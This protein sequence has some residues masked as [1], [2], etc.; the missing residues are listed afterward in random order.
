MKLRS[1][2]AE[3]KIAS[4][5]PLILV[6]EAV[7]Q[8]QKGLT[9][10]QKDIFQSIFESLHAIGSL[11]R[12]TWMGPAPTL[13]VGGTSEEDDQ[14]FTENEYLMLDPM[15]LAD[16]MK[17]IVTVRHAYVRNGLIQQSQITELW[18]VAG[19][20]TEL[21]GVLLEL[22]SDL[23][24]LIKYE[25]D[26]Y[27]VP[28][29]LPENRPDHVELSVKG[30][31]IAIRRTYHLSATNFGIHGEEE[32][33]K[34]ERRENFPVGVMGKVLSG[35]LRWSKS[36]RFIWRDG[37]VAV[38]NEGVSFSVRSER[39][40]GRPALHLIV[41]HLHMSK[42]GGTGENQEKPAPPGV[43]GFEIVVRFFQRM[44]SLFR[45]VLEDFYHLEYVEIV[46]IDDDCSDWCRLSDVMKEVCRDQGSQDPSILEQNQSDSDHRAPVD[47]V[48]LNK[49][50]KFVRCDV[51]CPDLIFSNW[52]E[53]IPKKRL[54]LVEGEQGILGKGSYG[55]V[56][57][58]FL[59]VENCKKNEIKVAVKILNLSGGEEEGANREWEFIQS[60]RH[61]LFIMSALR[62]PNLVGLHG[63]CM[64]EKREGA[65]GRLPWLVLEL[66]EGGDLYEQL[67]DPFSVDTHLQFALGQFEKA[68]NA[69]LFSGRIGGEKTEDEIKQQ[70]TEAFVK[71]MKEFQPLQKIGDEMGDQEFNS[72]LSSVQDYAARRWEKKD[73]E[74]NKKFQQTLDQVP[75]FGF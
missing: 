43:V 56:V 74:S 29:L 20:P 4:V 3:K 21:H 36:V 39:V 45:N 7:K 34:R 2:C 35:C 12:V 73:G 57:R 18:K 30:G 31:G 46:P 51:V 50:K 75:F 5:P 8:L 33:D 66:V 59:S 9:I 17:T 1:I 25:G 72:L 44:L 11:L 19:Y 71:V 61:E 47:F 64:M 28:F 69:T 26:Q 67:V 49:T 27:M 32:G 23:D 16:L 6:D 15:W 41:N 52:L 24:I 60:L 54:R 37:C 42:E 48:Q 70:Q 40:D 63:V 68:Y 65:G 62:H 14:L 38:S 55:I 13:T 53:T 58:G 22:L 10:S